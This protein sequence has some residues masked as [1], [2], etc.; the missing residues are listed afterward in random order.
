M[1]VGGLNYFLNIHN[2]L[3]EQYKNNY[4][5][6]FFEGQIV[7]SHKEFENQFIFEELLYDKI[8]KEELK[9]QNKLFE[10]K[11]KIRKSLEEKMEFRTNRKKILFEQ[12]LNVHRI[13][14]QNNRHKFSNQTIAN[15]FVNSD[16][17]PFRINCEMNEKLFA[18]DQALAEEIS[19]RGI[20]I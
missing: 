10:E 14:F 1:N 19:F 3:L 2:K 7:N 15:W 4:S 17:N 13:V 9:I 12:H 11:M 18:Y 8:F 6:E 16:D 20:L 5:N